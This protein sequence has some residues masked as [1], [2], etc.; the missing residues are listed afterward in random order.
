MLIEA[1]AVILP[2]RKKQMAGLQIETAIQSHHRV[3]HA[4]FLKDIGYISSKKFPSD[5]NIY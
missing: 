1:I 5:V 3:I 4:G 2:T